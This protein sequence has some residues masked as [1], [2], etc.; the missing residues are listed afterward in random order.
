MLILSQNAGLLFE[1]A[2][3]SVDE[4]GVRVLDDKELWVRP[5]EKS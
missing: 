5:N 3:L 2:D 1:A 4:A